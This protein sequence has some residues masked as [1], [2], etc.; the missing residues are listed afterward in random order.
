MDPSSKWVI[1]TVLL[2][3][4][5]F[6]KELR[7]V[8]SFLTPFLLS[9]NLTEDETVNEIY[10]YWTY[11]FTASL[12]PVFILTDLVRYKPFI[13]IEGLAL[14]GSGM[15]MIFGSTVGL[16]KFMQC[17]YGVAT[18]ADIGYFAYLYAVVP[19]ER[20]QAVSSYTRASYLAGRFSAAALGQ[21]L[22]TFDVINYAGLNIF[23]TVCVSIATI[24]SITLPR[25]KKSLFFH[26]QFTNEEDLSEDPNVQDNEKEDNKEEHNNSSNGDIL[27]A[28]HDQESNP[29]VVNSQTPSESSILELSCFGEDSS[30]HAAHQ[31]EPSSRFKFL[32]VFRQLW[33]EFRTCYSDWRLLQ[34]SIWWSVASC[35]YYQIGN[36]IQNLWDAVY[37]KQ[38]ETP[39]EL[40][41]GGV[42][43]AATLTG[44]ASAFF[45]MFAKAN[46]DHYGELLMGI[47][48]LV[49]GCLIAIMGFTTNIWIAYSFYIIFTATFHMLITIATFQ[50]AKVLTVERYALVFGW[51]TFVAL[52]LES[53]L[54]LIVVDSHVLNSPADLQ[55]IIY[56]VYFGILGGAFLVKAFYVL[57]KITSQNRNG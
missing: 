19:T 32:S 39:D 16:M 17:L 21:L 11:S 18:A 13:I 48:S 20:Y 5:G 55:F 3:L 35:G 54:T 27:P 24:I 57:G 43:A 42:E 14:V 12:I 15:V 46:W 34:W 6:I 23:G 38:E 52:V 37:L 4:F 44:A 30:Q 53:L 47:I 33:S 51:N 28:S 22:I 8:E 45:I 25:A 56:G 50:I 2:C 40:W 1:P 26:S 9:K 7:P 31:S 36:Y 10:P 41:Y 29:E 49:D